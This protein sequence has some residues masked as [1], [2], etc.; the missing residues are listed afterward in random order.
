MPL[1]LKCGSATCRTL[2]ITLWRIN[3]LNPVLMPTALK[4]CFQPNADHFE[5]QLK[6][7]HSFAD[8]DDIGVVVQPAQ[9]R[10]FD[11]PAQGA[12]DALDAIGSDGFAIA[13]TAEHN[14]AFEFA[15]GNTFRDRPDEQ[16]VI[17]W[18]LRMRAE[19]RDVMAEALQ[20]FLDLFLV[21]KSSVIRANGDFH[22][23]RSAQG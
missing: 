21:P 13:G 8:G 1:A 22:N 10:G 18:F 15:P 9:P 5:R 20:Q 12:A 4:R 6:T 17:H 3:Q 23:L 16:R 19:I 14:A 11:I 2:P 7:D